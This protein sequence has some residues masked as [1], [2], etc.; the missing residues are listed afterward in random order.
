LICGHLDEDRAKRIC[1]SV[2]E[3]IDHQPLQEDDILLYRQMVRL[4]EKTVNTLEEV[5]PLA[6]GTNQ[7]NPN[8]AV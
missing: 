5:N 1:D 7:V 6:E 8:S 4:P 3:S 2:N